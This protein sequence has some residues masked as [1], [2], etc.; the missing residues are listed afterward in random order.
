MYLQT[1]RMQSELKLLFGVYYW[2][3]KLYTRIIPFEWDLVEKGQ[4]LF[5]VKVG[6]IYMVVE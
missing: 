1:G 5:W 6:Y 3:L 4:Q 2:Y